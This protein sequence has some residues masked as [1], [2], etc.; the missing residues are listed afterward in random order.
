MEIAGATWADVIQAIV[1]V[2]GFGAV[3]WQI[4]RLKRTVQGETHGK[5]YTH[6]LEVNK[7]FLERPHLRPYFYEGNVLN[8]PDDNQ[9]RLRQELDIMCEVVL[10][11]LEHAVLQKINLP[12]DSWKNCWMTYV[13]DRYHKSPELTRFFDANRKW[14]AKALCDLIDG[15]STGFDLGEI[16]ERNC[17]FR[18]PGGQQPIGTECDGSDRRL[19]RG[20]R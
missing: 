3:I 1:A 7:L 16:S 14:Y 6:Y 19:L 13:R 5:L 12:N 8:E 9:P 10:G 4:R 15:K 17:Y 2:V 18:A 11:L 20:L